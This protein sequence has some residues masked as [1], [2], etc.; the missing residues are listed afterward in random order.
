ILDYV[1]SQPWGARTAIVIS[2]DHGEAFGEHPH[3]FRHGFELWDVL[4]HV[5][6]MIKAPGIVPRHVATPRSAIDLAPT[7]LELFGVPADPAMEGT[8]LVSELRGAEAPERDVILDLPRTSDSDR[9][10]AL[11][12][13]RHKL[14][15]LGDDDAFQ[16]F[17]LIADP[18]EEKEARWA[19]PSVFDE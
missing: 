14:L 15:A 3:V 18:G 12:R 11:I 1:A 5:P 2:A 16:L 9:R 17:D 8:S 19:T 4:T 13:G 6:L 7:I 10:R